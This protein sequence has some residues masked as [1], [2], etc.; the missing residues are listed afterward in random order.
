[1][2]KKVIKEQLKLIFTTPIGIVSWLIA[3][4]FWSS[5]WLIPLVI[6]YISNNEEFYILSGSIYFFFW[7]PLVPMWL[8]TPVTTL[9][10]VKLFK[11]KRGSRVS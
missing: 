6:G 10:I 1:M 8:I 11:I 5:F 7:Q 4:L 2:N 3:N 9:F